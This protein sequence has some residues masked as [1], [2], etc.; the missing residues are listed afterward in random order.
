MDK[1]CHFHYFPFKTGIEFVQARKANHKVAK[2]YWLVCGI[3]E[4][5]GE[6]FLK[7]TPILIFL[8]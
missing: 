8:N 2:V 5:A 1:I 7:Q 4:Y 6:V 3:G